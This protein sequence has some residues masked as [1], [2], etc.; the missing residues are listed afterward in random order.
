MD[1]NHFAVEGAGMEGYTLWVYA[2][3]V[4]APSL[5]GRFSD[6]GC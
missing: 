4:R 5:K 6:D 1:A 3:A 2:A